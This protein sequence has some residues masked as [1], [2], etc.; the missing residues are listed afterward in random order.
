MTNPTKYFRNNV[1]NG[2]NLLEAAAQTGVRKFVFSS[3]CATYGEPRETPI[4]ESHPQRPINAYGE[5]KLAI[6][7]ALPHYERAYGLRAV[8]LR[9][10]NAAGAD[11]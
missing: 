4:V 1:A 9:Y 3:T 5:S 2:L 8:V 7:R 6:E 11:I 10:F